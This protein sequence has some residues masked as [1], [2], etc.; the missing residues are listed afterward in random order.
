[1]SK[2]AA[3]ALEHRRLPGSGKGCIWNIAEENVDVKDFIQAALAVKSL[4]LGV[5]ISKV[6]NIICAHTTE[7]CIF[8]H[9]IVNDSVSG[10]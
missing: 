1:M 8:A 3:A 10:T 2:I 6:K 5:L 7:G 9:C 4:R